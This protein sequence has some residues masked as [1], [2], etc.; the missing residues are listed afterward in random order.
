[1]KTVKF[2]R[3]Q[4]IPIV[5]AMLKGS[6]E[7]ARARL[8]FDT[9]SGLTQIDTA[10]IEELGYSARDGKSTYFTFG[11]AGEKIS[12]YKINLPRLSIFGKRLDNLVVG[13]IDFDNFSHFG[14][15]GLLGFDVIKLLHLE[16][17]GPMGLL[18]VY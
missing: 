6:A 4:D 5:D 1:M 15:S 10:L 8:V 14:I 3:S 11:P 7:N 9:G 18:K 17:D 12:G 13:V 16:M 2:D